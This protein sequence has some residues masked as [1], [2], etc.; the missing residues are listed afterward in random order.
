MGRPCSCSTQ[1][2]GVEEIPPP[3]ACCFL[4]IYVQSTF[5]ICNSDVDKIMHRKFK[6]DPAHQA[7]RAFHKLNVHSEK[8]STVMN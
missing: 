7:R 4:K 5:Y 1:Q 8:E 2:H 3:G 6:N